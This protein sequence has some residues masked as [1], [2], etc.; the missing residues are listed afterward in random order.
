MNSYIPAYVISLKTAITFSA[1][2]IIC[3][4]TALVCVN[5]AINVGPLPSIVLPEA[6]SPPAEDPVVHEPLDLVFDED[7]LRGKIITVR[8]IVRCLDDSVCILDL[9]PMINSI[10]GL[11]FDGLP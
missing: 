10:I 2:A 1:A 6:Q 11:R 9:P 7:Q 3:L 4:A 8:T 5:I